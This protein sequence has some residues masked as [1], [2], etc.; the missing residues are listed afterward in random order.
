MT[1]IINPFGVSTKRICINSIKIDSYR[2]ELCFS[3][4]ESE[5]EFNIILTDEDGQVNKN[6]LANLYWMLFTNPE[7]QALMGIYY[8][9]VLTALEIKDSHCI[10]DKERYITWDTIGDLVVNCLIGIEC[11][12]KQK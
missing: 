6:D 7:Y 3:K 2:I 11:G 8:N 10:S 9:G 5:E 1:E 12:E 4:Y